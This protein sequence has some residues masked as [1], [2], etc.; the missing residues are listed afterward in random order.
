MSRGLGRLVP[1]D[2]GHVSRYPLT[3]AHVEELTKPAPVVIGINWYS[4][5]DGP[6][7]DAQ[8][9][10]WIG[11]GSLGSIR[12]GHCVALQPAGLQ[13][14]DS[15]WDWY[16]QVDEGICVG[17][18]CSRAMS[19]LNR[20]RYE[21]RWLYDR[22]KE[23]DGDPSGEG[24][25]VRVGLDVLRTLGHVRAKSGEDQGLK[26]GEYDDRQPVPGDGISAN[27][28]A[29]SA[30]DVLAALGTSERDYV[31]LIN[32]WGRGY[33]HFVRMPVDVLERL[34]HEDGEI[35]IVTDR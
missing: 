21:P 25:Y 16:D 31:V 33:P 12:G 8:G 19:L 4:N 13:D 14:L 34:R 32:S 30:Q 22:C 35:G 29:T 5:F 6:V 10:Y 28:W 17:E 3:A 27:R 20:R 11:R 1:P 7:K 18:G 26:P 23:R 9:H 24:T 15:W 2:W